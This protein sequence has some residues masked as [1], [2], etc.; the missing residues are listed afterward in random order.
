MAQIMEALMLIC[1]GISWPVSVYKS[2]TSRKT[3][4]K[5]LLFLLLIDTGYIVGLLGKI[6]YDFNWVI[7]VYCANTLFVTID[8]I[9]YF[10]NKTI[11]KRL[12]IAEQ[13]AQ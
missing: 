4:G 5:S 8:I 7:V 10:R 2:W 12:E 1:F 13:A 11:E 9:L 3:G 6:I